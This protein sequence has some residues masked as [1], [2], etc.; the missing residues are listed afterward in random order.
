VNTAKRSKEF[1]TKRRTRRGF[2]EW[3]FLAANGQMMMFLCCRQ[4]LMMR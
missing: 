1:G 2:G 3:S 4:L